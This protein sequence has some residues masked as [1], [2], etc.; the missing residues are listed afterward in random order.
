MRLFFEIQVTGT[1]SNQKI[2]LGL[3]EIQVKKITAGTKSNLIMKLLEIQV[4]KIMTQNPI[5]DHCSQL[6]HGHRLPFS[7]F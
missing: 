4:K 3:L 5:K 7:S 1:K 2:K 6:P